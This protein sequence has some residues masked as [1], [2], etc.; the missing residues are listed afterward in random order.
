MAAA[1][2]RSGLDE[3]VCEHVCGR[4]GLQRCGQVITETGEEN[5]TNKCVDGC[6]NGQKQW[7]NNRG[8]GPGMDHKRTAHS[9]S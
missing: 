5:P 7:K 2:Q 9:T 4:A 3:R 6:D 1:E 8:T